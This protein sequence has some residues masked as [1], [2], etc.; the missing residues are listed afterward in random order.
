MAGIAKKPVTGTETIIGMSFKK[1][2]HG[3]LHVTVIVIVNGRNMLEFLLMS[4]LFV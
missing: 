1:A 3:S 4:V 2:S